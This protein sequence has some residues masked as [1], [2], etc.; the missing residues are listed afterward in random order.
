MLILTVRAADPIAV[1]PQQVV[2]VSGAHSSAT[3]VRLRDGRRFE[4]RET[5]VEVLVRWRAALT[6]HE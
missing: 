5:F 6:A 2:A 3:L 1:D 4:V